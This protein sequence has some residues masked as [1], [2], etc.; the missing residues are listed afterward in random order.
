MVEAV[1]QVSTLI[2]Q[3]IQGVF[4]DNEIG[5]FWITLV[6]SVLIPAVLLLPYYGSL[7]AR[8]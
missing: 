4:T 5:S 6:L 8:L 1:Q 3:A 2:I 7:F